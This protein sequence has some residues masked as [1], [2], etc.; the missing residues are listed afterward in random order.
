L[1]QKAANEAFSRFFND[2]KL[3]SRQL[4]FVRQVVNYVVKNGV[5]KDLSVLQES[6]FTDMGSISK[7]FDN[8]TVFMNLRTVIEKISQN[9]NSCMMN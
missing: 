2:A 8:V 1:D 4:H 9:A 7:L 6:S 5:M 3:D